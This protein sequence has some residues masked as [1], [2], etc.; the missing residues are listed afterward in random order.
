MA[1][2]LHVPPLTGQTLEE[3]LLAFFG[4]RQML[5][6]VDN[7]ERLLVVAAPFAEQA[8]E[9]APG[10]KVLVT[11]REPLRL[12]GEK[13]V[14]VAPLA[15]PEAGAPAALGRLAAVPAVAFFLTCARDA[16]PDFKLTDANAAAV[17]EI[18]RRLD[19]LPLALQ[20]AAAR[21]TVLCLRPC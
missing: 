12:R 15:L 1:Q 19:G 18:C 4:P 20:L 9:G 11:S 5:L 10:L 6:L 13:V 8:L 16:R 3:S 2:Q 7:V 21:L 14:P 17:A